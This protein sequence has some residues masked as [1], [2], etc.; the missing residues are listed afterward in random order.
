MQI[1]IEGVEVHVCRQEIFGRRIARVGKQDVVVSIPSDIDHVF[2]ELSDAP[3]TVPS[4][5]G[6]RDFVSHK[7]TEESGVTG[8][9]PHVGIYFLEDLSSP[10]SGT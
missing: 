3:H 8:I 5:H 4:D 10:L 7:V 2:D 9:R 6:A 1:N